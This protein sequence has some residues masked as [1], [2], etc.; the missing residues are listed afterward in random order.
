MEAEGPAPSA[1]CPGRASRQ[2]VPPSRGMLP[3]ESRGAHQ[4]YRHSGFGFLIPLTNFHGGLQFG[5]FLMGRTGVGF[6]P[7]G[8]GPGIPPPPAVRLSPVSPLRLVPASACAF[9]AVP[10]EPSREL[11]PAI[12]CGGAVGTGT[13]C[14]PVVESLAPVNKSRPTKRPSSAPNPNMVAVTTKRGLPPPA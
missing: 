13:V 11:A 14:E 7:D 1:R 6:G 4:R 9:P 10:R 3:R 8:A 2:G 12:P 5:R